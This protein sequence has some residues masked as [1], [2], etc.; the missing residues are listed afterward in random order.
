ML[1]R[2]ALIFL[3]GLLI[4]QQPKIPVVVELFTSEG[5]S[6]CPPADA[7]LARLEGG[8]PYRQVKSSGGGIAPNIE[9]IAMG[10]HVD[11]WDS[12]GWKDAFSSP[13]FSARQQDY[14]RAFREQNVY[15]PQIVANGRAET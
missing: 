8:T 1:G 15:T 12:P 7:L 5:C 11:Y 3:Q 14:G 4:A 9:I 6:S 10:E 2:V 13:L